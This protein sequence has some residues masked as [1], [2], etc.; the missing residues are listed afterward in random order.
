MH[1]LHPYF[2][3]LLV[4]LRVK[5]FVA[6]VPFP[7][8]GL[9]SFLETLMGAG[10]VGTSLSFCSSVGLSVSKGGS[11]TAGMPVEASCASTLDAL[12]PSAGGLFLVLLHLGFLSVLLEGV[13]SL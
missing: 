13:S 3:C 5:D 10:S 9:S 12:G 7:F 2:H 8:G 1:S 4:F 11:C 6:K